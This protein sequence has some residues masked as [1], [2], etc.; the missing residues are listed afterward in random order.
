MKYIAAFILSLAVALASSCA[1]EIK[2]GPDEAR[3]IAREAYVY[4][5]PIVQNYKVMYAYAVYRDGAAFRAPFNTLAVVTPD[6][7]G[8]DSTHKTM[9]AEMTPYA[10]AWLDLRR[11]PA[12]ITVPALS[13]NR[14]YSVQLIDLYTYNFEELN[15]E[16]TGNAGGSFMVVGGPASGDTPEGITRVIPCETSFALAIIHSRSKTPEPAANTGA[17]LLRFNVETKSQMDGTTPPK[18]E[19]LIFPPYS[20]ETAMSAG[21]FQY[22][23]FA[24]Q[25]C[26]VHPGEI[27]LRARFAKLGIAAGKSF[28][29]ATMDRTMLDAVNQGIS[30]AQ[31]KIADEAANTTPDRAR[32][33]TRAELENDYLARA[34]AAKVDLYGPPHE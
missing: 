18:P 34:V 3:D 2:V 5:Y 1:K 31:K 10:M 22:L 15:T 30:E 9:P 4:G 29:I 6:T 24:L 32:Y 12:I 19:A 14:E 7:A 33:G 28:N 8:V 11:E 16:K 20:V 21:F 17:S 13:E 23:N 26:P 27:Q 25:F